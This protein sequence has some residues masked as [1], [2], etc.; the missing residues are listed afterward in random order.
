MESPE[1]DSK[2][3]LKRN[4]GVFLLNSHDIKVEIKERHFR[5]ERDEEAF[6]EELRK[7]MNN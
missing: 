1:A 6:I 7:N 5:L 2:K 3:G 4:A